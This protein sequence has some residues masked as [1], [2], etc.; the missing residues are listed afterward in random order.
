VQPTDGSGAKSVRRCRR[1][2][3]LVVSQ[4]VKFDLKLL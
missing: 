2:L 4:Y 3:T 1:R